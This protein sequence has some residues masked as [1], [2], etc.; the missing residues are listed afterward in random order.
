[1]PNDIL[2]PLK[3]E[4]EEQGSLLMGA[5]LLKKWLPTVGVWQE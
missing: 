2:A 3:E 1:V 4:L 5:E